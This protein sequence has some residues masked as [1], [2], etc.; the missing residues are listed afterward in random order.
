M[1]FLDMK[2]DTSLLD[3]S[4]LNQILKSDTTAVL[5]ADGFVLILHDMC[6][7]PFEKN[8]KQNFTATS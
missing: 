5:F 6:I 7:R 2:K 1:S 3:I 4:F 8:G